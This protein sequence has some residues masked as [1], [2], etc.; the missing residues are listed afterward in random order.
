MLRTSTRNLLLATCIAAVPSLALA[1]SPSQ[2]R[3]QNQPAAQQSQQQHSA[4]SGKFLA[5]PQSGQMRAADLREA[6]IYTADNQK[7]GDIDDILLDRQGKIV[8]VVVGVGGFLGIGQKNV[9]IP[10]DSLEI[11]DQNAAMAADRRNEN[12]TTTTSTASNADR[13]A[14]DRMATGNVPDNRA[15]SQD[16]ERTTA[17]RAEDMSKEQANRQ[18]DRNA[19]RTAANQNQQRSTTTTTT[20]T[21]QRTATLWKPERILL[22]GVTKADLQNAPEFHWDNNA[23]NRNNSNTNNPPARNR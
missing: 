8:A 11:Q 18:T 10:F 21:T 2:Q 4:M 20:T 19:D 13:A 1:Q 17:Q 22:K 3:Q 6:D 12:R 9:A 15:T 23:S 16:R 5:A 7:V 14:G